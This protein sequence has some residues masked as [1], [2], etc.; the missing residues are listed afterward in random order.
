[1]TKINKI[2]ALGALLIFF[3]CDDSSNANEDSSSKNM[4]EADSS[5]SSNKETLLDDDELPECEQSLHN[6]EIVDPSLFQEESKDTVCFYENFAIKDT[7]CCFGEP[8][9]W[10][11]RDENGKYIN[12]SGDYSVGFDYDTLPA[13]VEPSTIRRC[14]AR[15][16][17]VRYGAVRIGSQTWFSENVRGG[18]HCLNDEEKNCNLFGSLMSYEKAKDACSGNFRLPTKA[19]VEILLHSVGASVKTTY[20][21]G[22]CGEVPSENIYY[23][24]P[25]FLNS[26]DSLKNNNAY[27]FSFYEDGGILESQFPSENLTYS[28]KKTCFFLQSNEDANFQNALC[29]DANSKG[30]SLELLRK[31]AELYVRCIMK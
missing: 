30:A 15:I 7:I 2:L 3:A 18:G 9:T 27:E 14:R 24:V 23:D 16:G 1:M 17:D 4:V 29:Y 22:V 19:D 26:Q 11:E 31:G 10:L 21:K 5:N 28:T 25:L 20:T 13:T 12:V 8:A 6:A